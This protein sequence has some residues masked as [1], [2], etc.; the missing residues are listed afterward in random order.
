MEV[1]SKL[2]SLS[3]KKL[4]EFRHD[5]LCAAIGNGNIPVV[6]YLAYRLK[7]DLCRM[8]PHVIRDA[9]EDAIK[10]GHR[11][12]VE[13]FIF[14]NSPFI[15]DILQDYISLGD[16]NT[17]MAILNDSKNT[18]RVDMYDV[19]AYAI[20][21]DNVDVVKYLVETNKVNVHGQEND[22]YPGYLAAQRNSVKVIH[23]LETK[24]VQ[25]PGISSEEKKEEKKN[26]YVE[27]QKHEYE[28][29]E[30]YDDLI[31]AI[32]EGNYNAVK[33]LIPRLD[34]DTL[35]ADDS[36][37]LSTAAQ[38]GD[39]EIVELLVQSGASTKDPENYPLKE[40]AE[41]GHY[42]IFKFLID[43]GARVTKY[44]YNDILNIAK[45]GED[46]NIL[47]YL[48]KLPIRHKAV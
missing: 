4:F 26:K 42:E 33:R 23:Y 41:N 6:V 34:Q 9:L 47:K 43:N 30:L 25:V 17:V 3:T 18:K 2:D 14:E 12:V 24:G 39:L 22:D 48:K 38:L 32:E 36:K 7:T 27:S 20:Q 1:I 16:S 11:H 21:N 19:L 45:L 8:T 5:L 29:D 46:K 40:A 13:L 31:Q 10:S 35:D 44:D 15:T 28:Q 37:P